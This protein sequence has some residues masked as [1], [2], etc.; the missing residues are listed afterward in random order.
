M[1]HVPL[2]ANFSWICYSQFEKKNSLNILSELTYQNPWYV[3]YTP[4][5]SFCTAVRNWVAETNS[6]VVSQL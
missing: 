3:L 6:C 5:I 1:T 2:G 4:Y